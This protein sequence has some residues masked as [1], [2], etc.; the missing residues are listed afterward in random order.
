M[1]H[2]RMCVSQPRGAQLCACLAHGVAGEPRLCVVCGCERWSSSPKEETHAL[3]CRL[4]QRCTAAAD[5]AGGAKLVAESGGIDEA[6]PPVVWYGTSIVHGAASTRAGSSFTNRISRSITR[7][8]LVSRARVLGVVGVGVGV[9][10]WLAVI[11]VGS[12]RRPRVGA[13]HSRCSTCLQTTQP[14][15]VLF[16]SL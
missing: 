2:A 7:T 5:A 11:G 4:G 6:K 3:K 16:C 8:V 9:G 15:W 14:F 13:T 10:R 12:G 1:A